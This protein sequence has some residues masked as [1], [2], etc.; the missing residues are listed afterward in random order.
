MT[1]RPLCKVKCATCCLFLDSRYI[2]CGRNFGYCQGNRIRVRHNEHKSWKRLLK[3]VLYRVSRRR[4]V[5][6]GEV[7]GAM[8]PPPRLWQI[9]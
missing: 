7:G 4:A 5:G 6:F 1:N 2:F 9:T 8:A 3:T